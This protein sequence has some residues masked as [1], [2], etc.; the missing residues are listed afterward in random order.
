[1]CAAL[2]RLDKPAIRYYE[3]PWIQGS[4]P[5]SEAAFVRLRQVSVAVCHTWEA[6]HIIGVIS[7]ETTSISP[8][9]RVVLVGYQPAGVHV[10]EFRPGVV[11]RVVNVG[12]WQTYARIDVPTRH[13]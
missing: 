12:V 8:L 4:P 11:E 9:A 10:G 7:P 2:A 13:K 1:M 3:H 6:V 5:S